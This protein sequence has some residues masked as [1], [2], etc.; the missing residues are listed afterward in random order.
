MCEY[1]SSVTIKKKPREGTQRTHFEQIPVAA[2]K[3]IDDPAP[4]TPTQNLV[5]EPARGRLA[6]AI[7]AAGPSVGKPSPYEQAFERIRAEFAEMTHTPLTPDQMERLC[8][9][10][11]AIC[12]SVLDDLVR[13]RFLCISVNGSYGRW[14]Q[15]SMSRHA[16]RRTEP[17]VPQPGTS[18]RRSR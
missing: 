18:Q 9:V 5:I 7:G 16:G 14:S 8:G 17:S 3:A 1:C 10:D 4:Q 13:A 6:S 2:I 11:S 12:K 15:S